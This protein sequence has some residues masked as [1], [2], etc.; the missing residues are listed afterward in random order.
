MLTALATIIPIVMFYIIIIVNKD[1][2]M[3]AWARYFTF[4]IA[5]TIF[6]YM[7]YSNGAYS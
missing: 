5:T 1:E 7:M 6:L 2:T 4:A 3:E